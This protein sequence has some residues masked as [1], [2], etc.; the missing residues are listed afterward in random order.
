MEEKFG[1]L[2]ETYNDKGRK[3][4]VPLPLDF[5]KG[6]GDLEDGMGGEL[7]ENGRKT[8]MTSWDHWIFGDHSQI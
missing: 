3:R 7:D 5:I 4:S 8:C 1:Y 6:E 2:R